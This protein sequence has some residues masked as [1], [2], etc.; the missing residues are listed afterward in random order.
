MAPTGSPPM[1]TASGGGVG[2]ETDNSKTFGFFVDTYN[3]NENPTKIRP[4]ISQENN[5]NPRKETNKKKSW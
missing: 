1:K 3:K 4:K 5:E 2:N